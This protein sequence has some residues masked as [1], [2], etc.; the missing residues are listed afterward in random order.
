ELQKVREFVGNPASILG[1]AGTKHGEI[2]EMV[3][4]HGRNA[5]DL[6]NRQPLSAGEATGRFAPED[7]FIDGTAVQSK[8]VNGLNNNLDSLRT[9][10]D[11]YPTWG[12]GGEYF[13][14]PRD[15]HE[16]ILSVLK[17]ENTEGLNSRS[18][19]AIKAKVAD[20]EQ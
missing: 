12:E 14:I 1:S 7:Y 17:G 20:I 3:E 6:L 9:P 8:F 10:L 2:A 16:Q 13:H 18:L 11:R 19:N 15:H 4:V 5:R